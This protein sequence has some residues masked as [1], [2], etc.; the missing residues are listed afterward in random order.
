MI[1]TFTDFIKNSWIWKAFLGLIALSFGVWGV[2]DVIAPGMDPNIAVAVGRTDITADDLQNRFRR[3]LEQYKKQ[4]GRTIDAPEMKR[5]ILLA[6]VQD[7][8]RAATVDAVAQ[9]MGVVI[10]DARLREAI[11]E[12]SAFKDETGSFSQLQYSRVL[13]DNNLTERMF[14]KSFSAEIRQ[15]AVLQ[16]VAA[17]GAAPKVMVDSL[18]AYRG[19]TRIADS[20]LINASA[21]PAPAAP[22]DAELKKTYDEN[23]AA[24]TA[25]EY[26]K[27]TAVVV[28]AEDL[29]SPATITEE[30][31]KAYYD[32]NQARYRTHEV[33]TLHQLIFDSKEKAEAARAKAVPG[34]K[35]INI[36][37]KA[38]AGP[39]ADLGEVAKD[40]ALAKTLG[41]A[42]D[43]PVGE[44][45]QPFET[46]L[47]WHLL[48]V[49]NVKP[50]VVQDYVSVSA[51]IRQTLAADKGVD[52]LY[53]AS[54]V[55]DDGIVSGMPFPDLAEKVGGK[56]VTVE[57]TDAYGKDPRGLE[58]KGLFD[59]DNFLKTAFALPVGDGKMN[60][61]PKGYYAVKVES[62]TPAK[63]KPFEEVKPEV[64]AI[65]VKQK[66]IDAARE[67]AD[68]L[69]KDA[70]A[71]TSL[72]AI[73]AKEKLSVVQIGPVTRFGEP[74]RND[75]IID[76]K[77]TSPELLDKLFRAKVGDT[78]NA[79]VVDGVMIAR[80]REIIPASSNLDLKMQEAPVAENLRKSVGNDLVA[81]MNRSFGDRYPAKINN[82][83][84]DSLAGKMN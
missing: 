65:A 84:L 2:G 38:S 69:T 40:S 33:R 46:D 26:R 61:L 48:E 27:V 6:L 4:L 42:Y 1:Q 3:E 10:T 9:D 25:P 70:G 74:L 21:L 37:Q 39:V 64:I 72:A 8:S 51:Q 34:D 18:L 82:E 29:V 62:S 20:L 32:E 81:A 44:I 5:S 35:L 79:P 28:R 68:K 12:Q 47:G 23:I 13:Y 31:M 77:R 45:S 15:A 22:T 76:Q 54:T 60:E 83:T 43:T 7:M 49:A 36:S 53:D 59:N 16:P 55:L 56:L 80:L 75:I 78:V 11:R 52:A 50:E 14:L 63:A 73:A 30:Q 17:S 57:S 71:S 41:S 58:A 66:R 67:I 24:F 19:E